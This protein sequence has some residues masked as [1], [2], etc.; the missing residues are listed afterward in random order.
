M[1]ENHRPF[2]PL[3]MTPLPSGRRVAVAIEGHEE[4]EQTPPNIIAS[5]RGKLADQIL[6]IAFKNGVKVREDQG[7]AEILA[8]L[9]LDTPIP[10]EAV[11]AVAEILAKVYEANEQKGRS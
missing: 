5:G 11:V 9:D 8:Q 10:S 7:L 6:E 1:Q 2:S 3:N 4:E